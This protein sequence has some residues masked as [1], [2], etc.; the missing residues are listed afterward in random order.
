MSLAKITLVSANVGRDPEVRYTPSGAM[1][2][3]FTAATSRRWRDAN[4]TDQE[5]TTWW[6]VTCWGK[7]AETMVR[8]NEMGALA[9]GASVYVEGRIE[10]REYQANDGSTRTS[11]D[12]TA[13]EVQ[14]LGS[15]SDAGAARQAFRGAGYE[16]AVPGSDDGI[17]SEGY[18]SLKLHRKFIG[19]ELKESYWRSGIANLNRA[20]QER[21]QGMLF[22]LA[23]V[24]S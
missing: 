6:T 3:R 17:G 18:V 24:A 19:I 14:M 2:V 21:S 13:N 9:K 8:L 4:G 7:L 22:D 10:A 5:S 20:I 16:A 1:N 23:E 12:V 11:L 15:R